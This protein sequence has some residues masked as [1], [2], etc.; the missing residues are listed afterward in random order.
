M[1]SSK[2]NRT[3]EETRM[4]NN[5]RIAYQCKCAL[6]GWTLPLE[7]QLKN[8][9]N[10]GCEVHHIKQVQHGGT[11]TWDNMIL[12]CPNC[13]KTVHLL[14]DAAVPILRQHLKTEKDMRDEL[15]RAVS[16][17]SDFYKGE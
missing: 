1:S 5:V 2:R 10:C 16:S 3:I 15:Y 17:L 6:C 9:G 13:H 14:G 11:H 4:V 12:L 8:R 7:L